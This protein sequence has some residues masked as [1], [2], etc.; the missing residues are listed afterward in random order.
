[1]FY[2]ITTSNFQEIFL[3]IFGKLKK[4]YIKKNKKK[5]GHCF[6]F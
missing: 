6:F 3:A 1:M 2:E 5:V 4:I